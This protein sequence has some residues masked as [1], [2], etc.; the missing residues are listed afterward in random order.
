MRSTH[1]ARIRSAPRVSDAALETSI[2]DE[3][4]PTLL[5]VLRHLRLLQFRLLQLQQ[6]YD[7]L[8]AGI[9]KLTRLSQSTRQRGSGR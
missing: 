9:V 2:M 8:G 1:A 5:Q 7:Q 3:S 6:G 4:L